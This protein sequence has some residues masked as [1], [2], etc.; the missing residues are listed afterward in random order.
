V[1]V[2]GA[3]EGVVVEEVTEAAMNALVMA[4]HTVVV[5]PVAMEAAAVDMGEA[6]VDT[7]VEDMVEARPLTPVAM[8][9]AR[10]GGEHRAV[11][12]AG[13]D[14]HREGMATDTALDK[15]AA[16]LVAVMVEV[17]VVER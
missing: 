13:E 16:V 12:A 8:E 4:P 9:R 14:S 3:P 5:P 17:T 7:E 2:A 10:L 6:V 11:G 15:V 1:V